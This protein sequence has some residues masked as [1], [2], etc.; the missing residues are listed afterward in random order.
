MDYAS[1]IL[2]FLPGGRRSTGISQL[3]DKLEAY[4]S[5][6]Q[7]ERVREAY[8]FGAEKHQGQKRVS[9]EPYITH[10]VAVADILADLRLDADTLVAAILHDV[11]EDTP[12]AKA[13]IASIFGQVVAELVD[14]VSKLDQIQ[15]KNRQEAQA[16]SFRKMLLAMVRDIR[17]IMVKLA[18]RM[19]NMR[20]LGVMPPVKRR[21][22]A[23]ETLEIYA[24]IAE[25]LGLYAVK[26]ELEDLGFRALYPYR[27][28][29]LERELKRARGNQKE[30]IAKIAE[31]FKGALKKA[32]IEGAVEGREKHLYSIYKKMQ[33]KKISLNEMVDVYGFRIIVDNADVCYRVLG[34]V[35]SVYK[36]MP[37]RFKDYIAIP[38]VNGYQSLHTTLFGPNGVP[39]EVQ[40]RSEQMHRVAESGIAA[41]WKYKSGGDTFGGVEHDRAREWLASLVQIQEGGSSEEF[42]ESVKVDLFPDKVYVFTPKGK[43]LRLPTGATTVDFAYAIHTDVGNRCVAAKVDRRLVPLRTP[44]RNGQTVEIIT[45]KGA[46]PNPSWSSFLVTAKARAAIRQYLK[47]LKKGDALELGRR[48]LGLALEEFSLSLK[49]IPAEQIDAVVK[50]LNLRDADELYEKIGLGERLAPLVARRLQPANGEGELAHNGHAGGPLMIA[51]TEGLLV[52]YARCCFPIPND[53]IMAY[54]SAGRGVMIHRQ[55]CGNLAEYRKQ[56]DK[57]LSVAWEPTR[58]R[59]FS[60]EIQLEI[61]NRVG[62]L[63]AVA[64]SIAGT[65]TNIDQVSLEERDVNSSSLK[66]Q[67]QVRDRKH[68]ARVIRTVRRMPD[69]QRVFRSLA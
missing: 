69:V 12:T 54:L 23:R 27:Y 35:H 2:G 47:N 31:T 11:I 20:T 55:N 6:A 59:L 52:T 33:N 5:P 51:G 62:V 63:A 65:E 50:E 56:P 57:W 7:V 39:I 26:L 10:P 25:R 40:I 43:I 61:N 22:S 41:H 37:G 30:F 46:K 28:K 9:G 13:E 53:P 14:G 49:K 24:P 42:L 8:D 18:D 3:L 66:F 44:L 32:S 19:H 15:F 1:S 60:S 4:L 68:L 17:V 58:G 29:V 16:E 34:L 38:R 36:P 48:L 67:V 64:S 45:A 21:R